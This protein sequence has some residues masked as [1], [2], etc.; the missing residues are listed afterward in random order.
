MEYLLN[1]N[2]DLSELYFYF[3]ECKDDGDISD[4]GGSTI[5][6]SAE[7]ATNIGSY[8]EDIATGVSITVIYTTATSEESYGKIIL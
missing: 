2:I 3:Q 7:V 5:A 6:R 1:K 4:D 8:K